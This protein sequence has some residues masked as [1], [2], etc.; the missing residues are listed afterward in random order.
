MDILIKKEERSMSIPKLSRDSSQ[1]NVSNSLLKHFG[2][3][4]FHDSYKPLDEVFEK[5]KEKKIVFLLL[6]GFGKYIQ[7]ATK[8]I[9]PFIY[10]HGKFTVDTV[11]PP[12]TVA[13]T[14]SL[15]S[16]KY[17]VET[18]WLGWTLY[19]PKTD[20]F[21]QTFS[22]VLEGTKD[23]KAK[24][25]PYRDLMTF[26]PIDLLIDKA[27]GRTVCKKIL[28]F[29]HLDKD[30]NPD[31]DQF[32][33]AIHN[34]LKNNE[35][36]FVYAYW[37]D[38]DHSL[39]MKGLDAK[40]TRESIQSIDRHLTKLVKENP[41]VLFL[42]IADHGHT[43]VTWTDIR[44]FPDFIETLRMPRFAIEARL[45]TFWIKEGKEED[46][47]K[48]YEKHFS[49]DFACY[50]KRQIYEENVFG[51]AA[52]NSISDPF[53]GDFTLIATGTVA[54]FDGYNFEKM[55]S[56]HAGSLPI[57]TKVLLGIYND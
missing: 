35:T 3:A 46:F 53:I 50:S 4:T 48:A 22:G 52:K 23:Q 8:D 24:F 26:T 1:V 54:L 12:T 20:E 28:C 10:S 29:D 33:S 14:T 32:V 56:T 49:K 34:A 31:M 16:G 27:Q 13:A 18:G 25:Q 9:C 47:I 11:Y 45:A 39:H 5:N 41:D 55:V 37:N 7:E 15:L 38:P 43:P 17:P 57:E 6:D 30:N 51:Y 19:N 40:E 44:N 42:T 21:V 2:V 36:K